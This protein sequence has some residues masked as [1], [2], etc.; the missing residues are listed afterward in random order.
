MASLPPFLE[1]A[2]E[3]A[4]VRVRSMNVTGL[5]GKVTDA[6]YDR[7]AGSRQAAVRNPPG[8]DQARDVAGVVAG[9][10]GGFLEGHQPIGV[11]PEALFDQASAPFQ[12]P[13]RGLQTETAE[14]R[15]LR[16]DLV[17]GFHYAVR[18]YHGAT[19]LAASG[20]AED[21]KLLT[22][23]WLCHTVT[24]H[25]DYEFL[26]LGLRSPVSFPGGRSGGAPVGLR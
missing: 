10:L 1:A 6:D 20:D 23:P 3:V 26:F 18:R 13:S 25:P 8:A 4:Y 12:K 16:P 21:A 2:G 5:L 17:Q 9:D 19:L 7:A 11:G 14:F 24:P 22:R 15:G